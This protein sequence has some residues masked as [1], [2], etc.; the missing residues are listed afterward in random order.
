MTMF[1]KRLI[2]LLLNTPLTLYD[3]GKRLDIDKK[4]VEDDLRHL[5]RTL[6]RSDY[7][8]IVHPARCHKCGFTFSAGH[9]HKPGKC[10][11][12]KGTWIAEPLVE[13]IRK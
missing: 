4:E 7:K 12:C 1:R 10:P 13:I 8:L 9:L 11:A 3:I 2:E 6:K 5:I